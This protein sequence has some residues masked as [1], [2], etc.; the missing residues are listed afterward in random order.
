MSEHPKVE[1]VVHPAFGTTVDVEGQ[2]IRGVANVE[3]R[4]PVDDYP[5]VVITQADRPD[6]TPVEDIPGVANVEYRYGVPVNGVLSDQ[7]KLVIYTHDV[8][9]K[10]VR[11]Q[12]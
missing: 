1:I 10:P 3:F 6:A 5:H 2:R 4:H 11:V 12:V 7:R 8:T 9:A